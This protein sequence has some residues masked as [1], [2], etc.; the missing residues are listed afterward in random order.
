MWV[1]W[2]CQ[3]FIFPFFLFS[4]IFLHQ[5]NTFLLFSTLHSF[6]PCNHFISAMLLVSEQCQVHSICA[7]TTPGITSER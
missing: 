2:V 1:V 5:E 4:S 7:S 6:W 3:P